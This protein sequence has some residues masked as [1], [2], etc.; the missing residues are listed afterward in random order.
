MVARLGLSLECSSAVRSAVLRATNQLQ[1]ALMAAALGAPV[2]I[3]G[4][5][6]VA[7]SA[8]VAMRFALW[9]LRRLIFSLIGMDLPAMS[10]KSL[11]ATVAETAGSAL[12]A[13]IPALS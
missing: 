12:V 5:A 13:M 8:A 2:R 10:W 11:A 4:M 3:G 1:R 7:A 6:L 9:P